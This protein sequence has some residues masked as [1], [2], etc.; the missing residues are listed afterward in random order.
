MRRSRVAVAW[1]WMAN[2]TCC[3]AMSDHK[4]TVATPPIA[5]AP[6][7]AEPTTPGL[8]VATH[9]YAVALGRGALAV[10]RPAIAA[11]AVARAGIGRE[12]ASVHMAGAPGT[13]ATAHVPS[14][15][16]THCLAAAS[17]DRAGSTQ[18]LAHA[19]MGPASAP[20]GGEAT[21]I[22]LAV[23]G[24]RLAIAIGLAGYQPWT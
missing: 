11:P 2:A 15:R 19:T 5:H 13:P 21:R 9:R 23:A 16:S 12:Q 14:E 24:V 8:A 6:V 20:A 7:R 10:G 1:E 4:S 3:Y 22:G 18:G 17:A